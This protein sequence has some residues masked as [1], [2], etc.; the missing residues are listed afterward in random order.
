MSLTEKQ[1]EIANKYRQLNQQSAEPIS[2]DERLSSIVDSAVTG[3]EK[4]TTVVP[5]ST[6]VIKD[7]G[8][9][10]L[11]GITGTLQN[12][13][14]IVAKPVGKLMGIPEEQIGFTEEQL[15]PTNTAQKVGKFT[16]QVAEFA[17]PSAKI[18]TL[19]KGLSKSA[20][21]GTRALTSGTIATAQSGEI[22]SETAIATGLELVFPAFSKVMTPVKRLF[23]SLGSGLSGANSQVIKQ[24]TTNPQIAKQTFE[25]ISQE[26]G[27]S[28]LKKNAQTIVKGVQTI[29]K[30]AS[31]NYGKALES[32]TTPISKVSLKNA[33]QKV[34]K[35]SGIGIK[36]G[37]FNF[38]KSDILDKTIQ[39][40]AETLIR[41]INNQKDLSGKGVKR[42]LDELESKMFKSTGGDANRQAFNSFVLKL[43]SGFRKVIKETDKTL[44]KANKQ[45][46]DDLNIA[47]TIQQIMGKVKFGNT[48]ELVKTAS[49]L[50]NLFKQKGISP[51]AVDDFL[52]RIGV[53]PSDFRT[54]EA[55]RQITSIED[56]ANAKGIGLSE[57]IRALSSSVLPP[58]TIGKIAALTGLADNVVSPVF[59]KVK[60]TLRATLLELLTQE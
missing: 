12:I 46:Y 25:K 4:S 26:G 57:L 58:E 60:P 34:L 16:E 11:K 24:I 35:D 17:I 43:K 7:F 37:V 40:R 55:V 53:N 33:S 14:N 21:L 10:A 1:K 50:D 22:G 39:K 42:I 47:T 45:Y 30:E 27:E 20:Q 2:A 8:I 36:N 32:M 51:Q 9:G 59:N 29:R 48:A 18:G 56:V 28:I 6:N 41:T 13:G 31:A 15:T 52:N 54:T 49:K 19:T 38:T 3:I 5:K 44:E 23:G